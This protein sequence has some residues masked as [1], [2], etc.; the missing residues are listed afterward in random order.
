MN[1]AADADQLMRARLWRLKK[2]PPS[3]SL[4]GF[5]AFQLSV[6]SSPVVWAEMSTR[7]M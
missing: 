7:L 6:E 5:D 1:E 3:V 2:G 4:K